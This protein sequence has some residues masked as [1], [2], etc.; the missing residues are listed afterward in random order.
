M[1]EGGCCFG[2]PFEALIFFVANG[3]QRQELQCN[4][5]LQFGVLGLIHHAHLALAELLGDLV[6]RDSLADHG[7]AQ[8]WG[9]CTAAG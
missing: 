7:P 9:D 2:F 1:S 4:C 8:T 5:A 6:V 3:G